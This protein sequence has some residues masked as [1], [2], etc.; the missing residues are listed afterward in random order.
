VNFVDAMDGGRGK[1]RAGAA[2]A[3]L[4]VKLLALTGLALL[5]LQLLYEAVTRHREQGA[6]LAL[7]LVIVPAATYLWWLI[8]W[9][10]KLVGVRR[11]PAF[12]MLLSQALTIWL[13]TAT[14]QLRLGDHL[15]GASEGLWVWVELAA[16]FLLKWLPL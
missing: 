10:L 8:G 3:W 2:L 12:S 9:L 1:S 4:L 5:C 7:V 13:L 16:G 6:D 15:M 14:V 11:G